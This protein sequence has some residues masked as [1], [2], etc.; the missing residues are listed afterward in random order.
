MKTYNEQ[1]LLIMFPYAKDSGHIWPEYACCEAAI[2]TGWGKSKLFTAGKNIFGTKQHHDPVY[3][4][5]EMPTREYLHGQ[6][7]T[8]IAPF[9]KFPD[10]A[11]SFEDRMDTLK[12]LAPKYPHYAAALAA[13]TGEE[14]IEEVS[15]T[16]STDPN[17]AQSVLQ[18]YRA[19]YMLF[20][21]PTIQ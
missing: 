18:T 7:Q 20:D 5:V 3:E 1:W 16:W 13:H 10:I 4:T 8:V 19:H 9:I 15:K 6:W 14:F 17:R 2:E 12:R 11:A 21:V